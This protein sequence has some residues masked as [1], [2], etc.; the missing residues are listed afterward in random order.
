MTLEDHL[1]I[2]YKKNFE[3]AK[4]AFENYQDTRC[5]KVYHAYAMEWTLEDA[6]KLISD[7][8]E[9]KFQDTY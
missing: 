7:F 6:E 8:L 2:I 1:S 3:F 4:K 9:E 5:R